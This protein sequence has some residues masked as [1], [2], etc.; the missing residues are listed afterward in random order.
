MPAKA[1]CLLHV[2][3][4]TFWSL[5][6]ALIM[7][8]PLCN[9]CD[10]NVKWNNFFMLKTLG[11]QPNILRCHIYIYPVSVIGVGDPPPPTLVVAF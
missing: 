9:C 5:P 3:C 2:D 8:I 4:I 6:C 1:Q 7:L 10:F 11:V